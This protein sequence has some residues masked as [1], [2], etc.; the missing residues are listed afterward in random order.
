MEED[1]F[2]VPPSYLAELKVESTYIKGKRISD[3]NDST[4]GF[5]I[6]GI[7]GRKNKI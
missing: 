6:K 1:P 3:M 7:F 2:D 4:I 5:L